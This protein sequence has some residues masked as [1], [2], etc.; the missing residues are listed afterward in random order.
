MLN[1]CCF[2]TKA[3]WK[4]IYISEFGPGIASQTQLLDT[5]QQQQCCLSQMLNASLDDSLSELLSNLF[6]MFERY[7]TNSTSL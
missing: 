1:R 5:S 6:Q 7:L 3:K 2:C 4:K